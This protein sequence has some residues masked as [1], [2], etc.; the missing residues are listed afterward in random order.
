MIGGGSV[1]RELAMNHT[2]EAGLTFGERHF[3]HCFLGDAR[4]TRR[5]VRAADALLA[6]PAQS[7][8]QKLAC[9]ADYRAL[10]RLASRPQLTHAARLGAHAQAVRQRL[11]D[12][13]GPAVVVLAEDTT[14]LDFPGQP[15]LTLGQI[16]DGG[17]QGYRCHNTLA[18]DPGTREV[19]GLLDQILH[20]RRH[21]PARE[22]VA[23]KR[24]HPQ[25]ESRLRVRAAAHVGPAPAG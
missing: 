4:R 10:R 2:A 12:P 22:G 17:G 21:A 7:L 5:L 1:F 9:P 18:V 24:A 3:G 13:A 6:H 8:P 23:R 16:G 11:R 20:R 19:L 14:E 15:T 25:R